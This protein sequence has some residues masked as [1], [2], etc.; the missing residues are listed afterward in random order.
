MSYS[1]P[2]E[3]A[4]REWGCTNI[5]WDQVFRIISIA[6]K[7]LRFFVTI[8]HF[9]ISLIGCRVYTYSVFV[10]F[11]SEWNYFFLGRMFL[12][13]NWEAYGMSRSIEFTFLSG[14]FSVT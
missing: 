4:A 7:V 3:K 13:L 8:A 9:C 1:M 10:P 2:E 14:W 11:D 6:W 12:K 5:S